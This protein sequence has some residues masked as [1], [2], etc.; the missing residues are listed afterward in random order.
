MTLVLI[1]FFIAVISKA[2]KKAAGARPKGPR[3]PASPAV[4]PADAPP[5]PA[6]EA[7]E[8]PAVREIRPSVGLGGHDDSLYRGSMN[9]VTGEGYDPCH[10]EQMEPLSTLEAIE[11]VPVTTPG[12]R[13]D[14]TGDE[15]VRGIVISEILKRKGA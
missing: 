1:Y 6:A 11:H 10:E 2:A 7:R 5:P 9:A 13:L 3:A 8:A 4:P 15:L 14:W 12:L